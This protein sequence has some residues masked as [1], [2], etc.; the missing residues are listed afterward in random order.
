MKIFI[1]EDDPNRIAALQR[2]L[3]GHS[4]IVAETAVMA[5]LALDTE[6]FDLIFLDHDLGGDQM[7]DGSEKNTGSE[8]VRFME[9]MYRE[10]GWSWPTT[11][12]HS[13]NV[14]EARNMESAL[15]KMGTVVHIIPFTNLLPLMDSPN[16]IMS[17]EPVL[18]EC[19]NCGCMIDFNEHS[20]EHEC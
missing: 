18:D 12:I 14:Y 8:V 13:L 10:D 19:P 4:V 9:K 16:F 11:I 2:K 5:I 7:V 17:S 3:I 20:D 1:L 6:E 15:M